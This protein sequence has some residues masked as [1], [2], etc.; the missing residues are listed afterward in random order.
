MLTEDAGLHAAVFEAINRGNGEAAA[1]TM[2]TVV[3]DGKRSL[4]RALES[5]SP[6][7]RP[8]G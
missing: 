5:A 1:E 3:L 2:L 7:E 8:A 6:A 4:R